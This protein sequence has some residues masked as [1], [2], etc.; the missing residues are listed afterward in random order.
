MIFE[1]YKTSGDIEDISGV[2]KI[3]VHWIEYK[4]VPTLAEAIGKDW[5]PWWLTYNTNYREVNGMIAGDRKKPIT[6]YVI[7]LSA[8]ELIPFIRDLGEEVI[9]TVY[10]NINRKYAEVDITGS[11]EIYNSYKE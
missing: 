4:Y 2:K 11:L 9:V 10:R 3:D 6:I 5:Y 7:E 8:E 1:I